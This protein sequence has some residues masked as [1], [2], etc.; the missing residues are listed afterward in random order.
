[1]QGQ[2]QRAAGFPNVLTHTKTNPSR[3]STFLYLDTATRFGSLRQS[4]GRQI[5]L[6]SK[7]KRSNIVTVSLCWI[8][9]VYNNYYNTKFYIVIVNWLAVV[10]LGKPC[11]EYILYFIFPYLKILYVGQKKVVNCRN[12]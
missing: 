7:A 8:S 11:G 6:E 9:Q 5:I 12:M 2:L 1:M 3:P 10:K 4:S